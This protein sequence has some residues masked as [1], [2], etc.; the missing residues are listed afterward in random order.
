MVRRQ[1]LSRM[2]WVGRREPLV[3]GGQ[4]ETVGVDP[5]LPM[6]FGS[7]KEVGRELL[8]R[9]GSRVRLPVGLGRLCCHPLAMKVGEESRR[10]F[11]GKR[12]VGQCVSCGAK[13]CDRCIG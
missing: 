10:R 3:R 13:G 1:P 4:V 12:N 8:V 11:I 9:N 2:T 7:A 6:A 5:V